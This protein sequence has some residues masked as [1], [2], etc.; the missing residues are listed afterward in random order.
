MPPI[1]NG[2]LHAMPTPTE[3]I[4]IVEDDMDARDLMARV[5]SAEG[6]GVRLAA[7]GW[8]GLL[9]IESPPDL[10]LLD[11]ML[12]GMD[13]IV[14]LR[15]L[16]NTHQFERVPVVVV[17][18]LDVAD[19]VEKVRP[20]GVEQILSKG[21]KLFPQLKSAV[22]RHLARPAHTNHVDLPDPGTTV[23]PYLE[24]YFKLL[25]WG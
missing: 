19:V 23:R 21:D 4:L 22:K 11:I 24:L 18:A 25:A 1:S 3:T 2:A 16:R 6:Y 14:F 12:P 5:L 13:G 15:S 17:T 9:A 10:I 7:N 20:Y 8:E